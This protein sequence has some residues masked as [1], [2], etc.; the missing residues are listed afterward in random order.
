[1]ESVPFLG[2]YGYVPT[3]TFAPTKT[4]KSILPLIVFLLAVLAFGAFVYHLYTESEKEK[5]QER[6][7][8][9]AEQQARLDEQANRSD[10]SNEQL[11][12]YR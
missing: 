5:E 3:P 9:N 10:D 7:R 6:K 11:L 4:S 2:T 8:L 1:M 12:F